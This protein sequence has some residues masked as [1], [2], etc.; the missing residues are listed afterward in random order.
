[1]GY[2]LNLK[3]ENF[4][5]LYSNIKMKVSLLIGIDYRG[6]ENELN[7]CIADVENMAKILKGRGYKNIL[8]TENGM[9]P[10]CKN[11]ML[12][13]NTLLNFINNEGCD[14]AWI[15]YSGHG[16]HVK[17]MDGDEE[18]GF[19]EVLVPLDY[20]ERGVISDDFINAHFISKIRNPDLKLNIFM[21]CCHSGTIMDLQYHNVN[22]EWRRV[23]NKIAI[24]KIVCISGCR[25]SEESAESYDICNNGRW[26]GAMTT[27]FLDITQ[28]N[29]SL[30][31]LMR[32]M[33]GRLG[34]FGQVP[35]LTSNYKID[36][37]ID[38]SLLFL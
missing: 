8:L 17:D 28:K 34:P 38:V 21:D 1:M 25:D 4:Y 18:D 23:N 33:K 19:D 14:E 37:D 2:R 36:L 22:E 29:I 16:T 26:S 35:Q 32:E 13:F 15:H 31:E 5:Y 30:R 24:G 6:H 27:T 9:I 10:N 12:G 20:R 3:N 11:I 7:G